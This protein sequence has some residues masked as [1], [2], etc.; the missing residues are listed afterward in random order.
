LLQLA[1]VQCLRLLPLQA[2]PVCVAACDAV[3]HGL[4]NSDAAGGLVFMNSPL[5]SSQA[6][7]KALLQPGA[8]IWLAARCQVSLGIC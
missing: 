2:L 8:S 7:V 6:E 4:S 5:S 1:S 3:K